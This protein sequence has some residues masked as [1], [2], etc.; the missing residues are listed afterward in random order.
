M[1]QMHKI[2]CGFIKRVCMYKVECMHMHMCVRMG[3]RRAR[4]LIFNESEIEMLVKEV[5][6]RRHNEGSLTKENMLGGTK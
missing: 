3:E 5:R 1:D 6:R 4:K 2:L